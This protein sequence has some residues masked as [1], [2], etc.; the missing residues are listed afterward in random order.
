MSGWDQLNDLD[1][2]KCKKCGSPTVR[3]EDD[4]CAVCGHR[5]RVLTHPLQPAGVMIAI[6]AVA[7][8]L[9]KVLG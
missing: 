4:I 6:T 5:D 3:I 8:L 9:L 2:V 7:V 1:L